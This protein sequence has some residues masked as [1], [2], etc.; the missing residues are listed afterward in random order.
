MPWRTWSARSRCT[1]GW[2]APGLLAR[3]RAA[4][5]AA[6]RA[7]DPAA[8]GRA[9]ALAE[10]ARAGAARLGLARLA[11]DLAPVGVHAPADRPRLVR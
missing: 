4:L 11:A 7:H 9:A 3:S 1:R 2:G 10:A 6:L 8:A 5:A